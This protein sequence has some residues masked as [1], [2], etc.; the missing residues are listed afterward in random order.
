VYARLGLSTHACTRS[1]LQFQ[2]THS[3]IITRLLCP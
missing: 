1:P 2:D 3:R